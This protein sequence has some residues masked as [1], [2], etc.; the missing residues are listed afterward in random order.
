MEALFDF[1]YLSTLNF[2]FFGYSDI[3]PQTVPALAPV[4]FS[5]IQ[6]HP[7]SGRLGE[8]RAFSP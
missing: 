8:G 4:C 3:L 5:G 1:V 2:S 6:S 7:P